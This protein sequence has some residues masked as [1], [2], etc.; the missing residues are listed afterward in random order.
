MA[1]DCC[2]RAAFSHTGAGKG[3]V[4]IATNMVDA[5]MAAEM[6][7]NHIHT[8]GTGQEPVKVTAEQLG[9]SQG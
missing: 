1:T 6:D 4:F 9:V 2:Q 7:S 3:A 5:Q 8:N